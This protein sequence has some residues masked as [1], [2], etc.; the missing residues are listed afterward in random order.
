M[1]ANLFRYGVIKRLS[2]GYCPIGP[3]GNVMR[4]VPSQGTFPIGFSWESHSHG[5][6][7]KLADVRVDKMSSEAKP[8][9]NHAKN[10][11]K[12]YFRSCFQ[13]YFSAKIIKNKKKSNKDF[14]VFWAQFLGSRHLM[15]EKRAIVFSWS[16]PSPKK[17]FWKKDPVLISSVL[18]NLYLYCKPPVD[19]LI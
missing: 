12:K 9:A 17:R 11:N 10:N 15:S 1:L 7:C 5:Q 14:S 16:G 2:H 6:A 3:M 19:A 18:F 8:M 4:A 13:P